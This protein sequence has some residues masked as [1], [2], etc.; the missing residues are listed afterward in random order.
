MILIC[1]AHCDDLEFAAGATVKKYLDNGLEI[2]AAIMSDASTI[3]GN[4]NIQNELNASMKAFDIPYNTYRFETMWFHKYYQEIRDQIFKLKQEFKPDTVI[5]PSINAT[6]PDHK[7][8]GEACR[9]IFLE[10]SVLHFEDVRGNHNQLIN[11]WESITEDQ[12]SFKLQV[13]G[14]YTSQFKRKYFD[15][16][17]IEALALSR[18]LQIGVKLAEGFEVGRII[19]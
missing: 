15:F 12:L 6:H 9:S 14:N 11:Y 7:I 4:E 2:Q 10:Q 19:K 17:G 8:V 18:G 13:L 3:P 1:S 16:K 5:C